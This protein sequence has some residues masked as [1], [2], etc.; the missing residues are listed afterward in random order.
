MHHNQNS[1]HNPHDTV[2][3]RWITASSKF[4]RLNTNI[5]INNVTL[6]VCCKFT[7]QC[8]HLILCI[9]DHYIQKCVIWRMQIQKLYEVKSL[10]KLWIQVLLLWT[11]HCVIFYKNIAT[12]VLLFSW[13]QRNILTIFYTFMKMSKDYLWNNNYL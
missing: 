7:N 10:L 4:S 6:K 2:L 8:A 1:S 3:T 12:T 5:I 13:F 9:L 11:S